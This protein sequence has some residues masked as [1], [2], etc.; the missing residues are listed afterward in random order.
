MYQSESFCHELASL[1]TP[2]HENVGT[3]A[4]FS[5]HPGGDA[6]ALALLTLNIFFF[7]I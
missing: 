5:L 3:L 6:A 2:V 4:Y 1:P 7:V